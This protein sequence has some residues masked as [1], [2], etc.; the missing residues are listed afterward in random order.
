MASQMSS[1]VIQQLNRTATKSIYTGK[2]KWKLGLLAVGLIV[3]IVSLIYSNTLANQLT[4]EERARV[5]LWAAA[6]NQMND[7]SI[8]SSIDANILLDIIDKIKQDDKVDAETLINSIQS[9]SIGAG[10]NITFLL[11]VIKNNNTIPVILTDENDSIVTVKN[12]GEFENFKDN[13][14]YFYKQLAEIKGGYPPIVIDLSSYFASSNDNK[15]GSKK[16]F[17][18]YA[19]SSLLSQLK[20]YPYVQFFVIGIFIMAAYIAFSISRRAEQNKVWLGMAKETAHQLGTPLSS[21]VGWV[22]YLRFQDEGR[23]D[24]QLVMIADEIEKDVS[25]L[26][27]IADRFSKI[28]SEPQLEDSDIVKEVGETLNY[29]QRRA[30]SRI[31]FSFENSSPA[32]YAKV[33]PILFD[34]VIENLLKNAL[35]AMEGTGHIGVKVSEDG[36]DVIID[37]A[38]SGKGIPKS[39]FNTIFEPG[40]STKKRGWGLGLSL[41]KRIIENNHN[42]RIFVKESV[43]DK[44][45]TFR[46]IIPH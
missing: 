15:G 9:N 16:Q 44:G 6:L 41:S 1:G 3:V 26:R 27:L 10:Q 40:F 2:D 42:G 19:D 45:T 33:S 8:S 35:D 32:I 20:S 43:I 38:D 14:A 25:R 4:A 13:P 30:A 37:V 12:F 34:W 11:D 28:G 7:P 23:Q 24:S 22:E 21:L 29:I 18:Y 36:D 31:T 17:I 39:K 5:A 46:I